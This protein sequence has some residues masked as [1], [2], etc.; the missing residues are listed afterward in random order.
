LLYLLL[1]LLVLLFSGDKPAVKTADGRMAALHP[2]PCLSYSKA[3]WLFLL[4]FASASGDRL[5]VKTAD[6]RMAV[7][8]LPSGKRI[9]SWRVP[10]CSN[11]T[12]SY[13]SRCCFGHTRDGQYICVGELRMQQQQQQQRRSTQLVQLAC[14]R[15]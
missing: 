3:N 12:A 9:S 15:L 7:F 10:G 2:P 13:S 1:L 6:G 4:L 14:T 8:Q 5:A 11:S